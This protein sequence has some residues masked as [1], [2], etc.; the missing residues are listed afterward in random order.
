MREGGSVYDY[1]AIVI[2]VAIDSW[3]THSDLDLAIEYLRSANEQIADISVKVGYDTVKL[4]RIEKHL[5]IKRI[6]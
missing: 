6:K 3:R 1:A 5:G 4:G 2:V